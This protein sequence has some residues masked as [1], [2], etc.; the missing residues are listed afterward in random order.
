MLCPQPSVLLPLAGV[1]ETN[2]RDMFR[3]MVE[4]RFNFMINSHRVFF[5]RDFS[6]LGDLG[7]KVQG[8]VGGL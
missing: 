8:H 3:L 7:A 5:R 1:D 6:G 4:C 2:I